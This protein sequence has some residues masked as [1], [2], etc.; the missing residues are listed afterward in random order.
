V[1]KQAFQHADLD[2]IAIT[3]HDEIAGTL[4]AVKLAARY[5]FGVIPGCEIT[6]TEGHLLAY[7]FHQKVPSGYLSSLSIWV[8]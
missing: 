3:D 1:L 5:G 8:K 7:F 4:E 2:V 6:A